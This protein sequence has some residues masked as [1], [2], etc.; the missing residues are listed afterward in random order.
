LPVS[1]AGDVLDVA[2]CQSRAKEWLPTGD[3]AAFIEEL[4]QPRYEVG[5][6]A[7]WIARPSKGVLGQPIEFEYVRT[8][9]G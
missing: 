2:K 4:M 8:D 3:D 5:E 9:Q 1:P 7:P 6:F